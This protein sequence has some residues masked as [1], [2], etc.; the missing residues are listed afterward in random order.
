MMDHDTSVNIT[1]CFHFPDV[2]IV[3]CG[4]HTVKYFYYD[5]GPLNVWGNSAAWELVQSEAVLNFIV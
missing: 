5:L 1:V 2:D 3:Y 4:N